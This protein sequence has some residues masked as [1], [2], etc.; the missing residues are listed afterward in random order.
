[1]KRCHGEI[2]ILIELISKLCSQK[3]V[4]KIT[5]LVMKNVMH[6]SIN[7]MELNDFSVTH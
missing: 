5:E 3:T 4:N 7:V 1:M 2:S 6:L